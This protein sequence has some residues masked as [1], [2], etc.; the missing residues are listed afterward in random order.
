MRVSVYIHAS[1]VYVC[2]SKCDMLMSGR[3]I[4]LLGNCPN[5]MGGK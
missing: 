3:Y 5:A 4:L 1:C 2:V